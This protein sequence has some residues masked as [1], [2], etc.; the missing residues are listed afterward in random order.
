MDNEIFN[1][2]KADIDDGMSITSAC[3]KNDVKFTTF[4][5]YCRIN[6]LII[7]SKFSRCNTKIDDDKFKEFCLRVNNGEPVDK[8]CKE[9]NLKRNSVYSKA[10]KAGFTLKSKYVHK[11]F[12]FDAQKRKS[13]ADEYVSGKS[14]NE[15]AKLYDC[16][17]KVVTSAV[18]EFGYFIRS[19]ADNR[20][21]RG[22]PA[23]NQLYSR[24]KIHDAAK[25]LGFDLSKDEFI[26]LITNNCYYCGVLPNTISVVN[27]NDED[28]TTSIL[29]NGIDRI[30]STIGYVL[31]NVV[32]ACKRCNQAKN[33][34]SISEFKELVKRIYNN[35]KLKD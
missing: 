4:R 9:L 27:C 33:D 1:L 7:N 3:V 16:S 24:Y 20:L 13:I 22:N 32:S 30:D 19:V 31:S 23:I 12:L 18:V 21:K 35:M 11:P 5:S 6:N 14:C 29:Y 26:K 34:M 28:N 15:L 17:H 25:N 2:I 10:K 8:L